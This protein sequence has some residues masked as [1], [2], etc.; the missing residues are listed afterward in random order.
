[1]LSSVLATLAIVAAARASG[2]GT[3]SSSKAFKLIVRAEY[4]GFDLDPPIDNSVVSN[5]NGYMSLSPQGTETVWSL[6]GSNGQI[7]AD[8]PGSPHIG[9]DK[10]FPFPTV[11]VSPGDSPSQFYFSP[12]K[13]GVSYL[14]PQYFAACRKESNELRIIHATDAVASIPYPYNCIPVRILPECAEDSNAPSHAQPVRCYKSNGDIPS[15][16]Y[17][18][19]PSK[20]TST[21]EAQP[22]A[23]KQ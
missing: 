10:G 22:R 14:D 6:D 8:G 7:V 18:T 15:P 3:L 5:D 19:E 16:P 21:T 17:P 20:I 23:T 12:D 13:Y 2:T 4:S 1:M 11:L 9:L